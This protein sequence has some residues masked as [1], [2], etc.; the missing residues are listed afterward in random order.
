[1]M[2]KGRQAK[3]LQLEELMGAMPETWEAQRLLARPESSDAKPPGW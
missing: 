3:G 2:L 1:V